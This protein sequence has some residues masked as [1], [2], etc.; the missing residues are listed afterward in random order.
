MD[1][2]SRELRKT[3][4]KTLKASR[5][6]HLGASFSLI[7]ILRVLYDDILRYD[8]QNPQW[9]ERDR[10]I[11]SKGH[12]CLALYA[13]LADKGFFPESELDKFC[14]VDGILGGHPEYGKVPGVEASTGSL[15]HGLSIGIGFALNA[16]IDKADYRTFVILGDGESQ[17]G[18]IWEAAMCAGKH[19]LSNLTV[20][21]DY[22]KHQS[23][24]ST[25]EVQ[26]LE[27]LADKWRAF[28]FAA[29]E[30]DGHDVTALRDVL[31]QVPL[32]THKPTAIICHTIKGKGVDFAE[33]N[34]NWHHKSR[35]SDNEI[36]AMLTALEG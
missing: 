10:C 7:E 17:E 31:S 5:R 21:M 30:V 3:I 1:K 25:T 6:G 13:I 33:N 19:R 12:G 34:L 26:D 8:S 29:V 11:L 35:I 16:R 18:S 15:G 14:Q 28:G 20:L 23:Y 22:N 24:G 27:P 4:V 9:L 32:E 2:R 36:Q